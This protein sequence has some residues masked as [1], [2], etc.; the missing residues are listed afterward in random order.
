MPETFRNWIKKDRATANISNIVAGVSTL[1]IVATGLAKYASQ[2]KKEKSYKSYINSLESQVDKLSIV[3]LL[4][5]DPMFE[6]VKSSYDHIEPE[7]RSHH[8]TAGTLQGKGKLAI[9]PILFFS[10]EKMELVV[11]SH[12]GSDMC[13]H[14]GIVHGGMI[15][16]L[17][18][19][20]FARTAIP[21]LPDRNGATA[22]LHVN[23]RKP[24]EA[25]QFIVGKSKVTKLEGRK[26]FVEGTLE[27]LGGKTV[28]DGNALFISIKKL[29]V[30]K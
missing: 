19:E 27:T 20:L 30:Q 29:D 25:N 17:M 23:F 13:G 2:R 8:F 22:Y 10:N 6:E 14:T 11:I 26:G 4:R 7:R 18:D 1:L 28:A 24:L 15:S 21:F 9:R 12:V 5:S 16:T 3:S